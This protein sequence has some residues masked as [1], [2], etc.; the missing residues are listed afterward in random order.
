VSASA[1]ADP[2]TFAA[3]VLAGSR[4]PDDPV[5]RAR[6]VTHKC[7]A[8][9]AGTPM[10][11]RVVETL[12]ASPSV[13]RIAIA[14]EDPSLI[15]QL[16]ALHPPREAG[17]CT[18]IA[19]G[20]TP[21]LSVL[22]ALDELPEPLPWLVATG[23]HPL[24]TPEIVEHFCAAA[25]GT[26]ADLVA[27]LTPASAVR[28]AY[29]DAVRTY[30]RFRD[31]HYSGANLYALLAPDARGA[32][33]FWR[34][35]ELERKRPWRLVRAFGWSPLLAY[36]LGRL[37]LDAAMAR[38]SRIVGA[39]IAAVSLPFAEAAIDVDKPADLELVE[40]ILARRR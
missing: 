25:R 27:G 31:E 20:T 36:L 22:R 12:L 39:R 24:L 6:G 19:T 9:V 37:T 18:V 29:P 14:L 10:L 21:S 34:R 38:A 3:L 40:A 4:G 32:I 1:A 23:D 30:L 13:G 8:P 2:T 16:P 35:A 28:A 5:A 11:V 7:L 26:G 15:G 17:R 33:A